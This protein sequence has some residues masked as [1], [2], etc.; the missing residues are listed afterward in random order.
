M[1]LN[2]FIVLGGCGTLKHLKKLGFQTFPELFD[3]SYDDIFSP[4][5]GYK[6]VLESI[7]GACSMDKEK[8][9]DL[10]HSVLVD[11]VKYNQ[12]LYMN[13]D[14]KK[15]FDVFLNQFRWER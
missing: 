5:L 7:R 10:Y 1:L 13:Y 15:M 3:E 9:D 2:P 8:I 11:K 4:Q 14:R 6:K 12:D